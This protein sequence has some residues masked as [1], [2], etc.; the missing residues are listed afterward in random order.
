MIETQE[1]VKP[2]K[3]A[4][5]QTTITHQNNSIKWLINTEKILSEPEPSK[6]SRN[7]YFNNTEPHTGQNQ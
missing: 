4:Q 2:A 1:G 7:R 5:T 3:T 6:D